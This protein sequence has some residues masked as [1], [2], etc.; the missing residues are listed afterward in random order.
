MLGKPKY[1]YDEKVKFKIELP[2][3]LEEEKIGK[4][5]IIDSYGTF[6]NPEDVSYDIMVATD[7]GTMCLY[8]HITESRVY[9]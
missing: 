9:K 5:A 6:A 7:E 1:A 8:K 3:G 4:V 2:N